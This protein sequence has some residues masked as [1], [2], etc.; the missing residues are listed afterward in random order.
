MAGRIEDARSVADFQH[1]TFSGHSRKLAVKSLQESI[2]L[3]RADYAC[4]WALE[5]LCSGLVH[6][7]WDT[8]FLA[9]TQYI[10]RG[11]PNVFPY[12]TQQYELFAGLQQHYTVQTI[13]EMRNREDVRYLVCEVAGVLAMT[14]KQKHI[15][16]PCI[17]PDRDFLPNI[18]R[19]NL[20]ATTQHASSGVQQ[21]EDPVELTI[22]MNEF[23]YS[24]LHRDIHTSLYWI[25]WMNKYASE[26][27]KNTKQ[28]LVFAAREN[29][30]VSDKFA[31]HPV[32]LYWNAVL[33][34]AKQSPH[35]LVLGPYM[36][37]LFRMY[38]LRWEPGDAR[39]RQPI[40]TT[41][42]VLVCESQALDVH[43]P[44]KKDPYQLNQ[45]LQNIPMWMHTIQ[46]T[47]GS[48]TS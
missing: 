32:W 7:L 40:L 48:F 47:K 19:E 14:R 1:F 30:Y 3:G 18:V 43:E 44:A 27:K 15:N 8:F 21:N 29:E 41:A 13:T 39:S 35:A 25:A 31:R 23:C 9:S 28:T 37:A 2:Q 10:H 42:V 46:T 5:L 4:Y 34:A 20:K 26:H 38:C 17:K 22:P 33:V 24:L 11:C 45:L 16:L 6:T 36:D 12:L